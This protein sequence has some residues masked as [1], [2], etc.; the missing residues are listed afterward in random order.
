MVASPRRIRQAL[1]VWR[2]RR[3]L[4]LAPP[5]R[6]GAIASIKLGSSRLPSEIKINCHTLS[7][8]NQI[9]PRSGYSDSSCRC[10]GKVSG[11]ASTLSKVRTVTPLLVLWL[12]PKCP[13]CVRGYVGVFGALGSLGVVSSLYERLLPVVVATVLVLVFAKIIKH[14]QRIGPIALLVASLAIATFLVSKLYLDSTTTCFFIVACL[15]VVLKF[16]KCRLPR[17]DPPNSPSAPASS[18]VS[19]SLI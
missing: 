2:Q 3:D 19:T 5:L 12:L 16:S 14:D 1:N 15:A 8:A 13:L 18:P 7:I 10:A 17:W 9:D 6:G 11:P 4:P